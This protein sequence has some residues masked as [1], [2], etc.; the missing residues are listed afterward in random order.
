V[1]ASMAKAKDIKVVVGQ[2][3]YSVDAERVPHVGMNVL[4]VQNGK[5]VLA[6]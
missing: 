1:R 3:L 4:V 6:P 5:F 2:G